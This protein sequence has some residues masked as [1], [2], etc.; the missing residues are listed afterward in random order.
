ME[1]REGKKGKG[2]EGC[3]NDKEAKRGEEKT[4][5]RKKMSVFTRKLKS[6]GNPKYGR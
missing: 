3:L 6:P 4:L 5:R 2:R 1:R